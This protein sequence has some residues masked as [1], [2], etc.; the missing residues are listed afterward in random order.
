[1]LLL[2]LSFSLWAQD[3]IVQGENL[4][5]VEYEQFMLE[6]PQKKTYVDFQQ[7]GQSAHKSKL[8][9]LLKQAQ[10]EFLQGS[11]EKSKELYTEISELRHQMD[12]KKNEKKTIHYALMRLAQLS[13]SK[14]QQ[15]AY[16]K[17]ALAWDT[18][19]K[20]DS[21]L[22]PPPLVRLYHQIKTSQADKVWP[23]PHKATEFS[24]ITVNGSPIPLG[25]SYIKLKPGIYR[26]N[27]ISNK[28]K[29]V[30]LVTEAKNLADHKLILAPL[31]SGQCDSPA[32]NEDIKIK[33]HMA[34]YDKGCLLPTDISLGA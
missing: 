23:L 21:E 17:K 15:S 5:D 32:F 25:Q 30:S 29:N 31:A 22:F 19:L 27:F 28:Y 10:Y 20:P 1:M 11:L 26:F 2:I 7:S 34:L 13:A 4:S 6:N 8:L 3:V 9:K 12:W 14:D 16:I 18:K 24:K 33:N